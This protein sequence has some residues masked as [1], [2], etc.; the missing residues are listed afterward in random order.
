MKFD[1]IVIGSGLGGLECGAMLS[2]EGFN[3]CVL[4]KHSVIG[5]CLQSFHRRGQILDTGIHYVGSLDEGGILRQYFKY[6]G[7]WDRLKMKRLDENGFDVIYTGGK[8]YKYPMGYSAFKEQ[9]TE[10]FPDSRKE[11]GNYIDKVQE[12][13]RL[14]G[15]EQLKMGKISQGGL[16]F[17]SVSANQTINDLISNFVLRNVL[18]GN[19]SLFAG[20]RSVSTF[21]HHAM[22]HGSNI[23]GAYRFVD[24]SQQLADAL[25]AVIRQNGGQ[26]LSSSEVTKIAVSDGK[27]THVEV[28]NGEEVYF[29]DTFISNL[30]PLTTY[31]L[32]EKN[33][34][35]KKAY[36]TRLSALKNSYGLFTAYL[37]MKPDTFPYFNYNLYLHDIED[38]WYTT[39]Y[40]DD[41]KVRFILM[42]SL[43]GSR[44][45]KYSDVITLLS[46]MYF[47]EVAQW[48]GSVCMKRGEDY[49]M[50]KAQ[51]VAEMIEMTERFSPGLSRNIQST[52]SASP[53]T[54]LDYTGT[55]E[56]SAY[57]LIKDFKNPLLT[58]FPP[59]TKYENL[60]LTGQ[61][62]NVHGAVGVTLTATLTCAE[63][64][65][66]EYLAKKIG[67]L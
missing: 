60:L 14:I 33:K 64:L 29:A 55:P 25:V 39:T 21:Y 51:K 28:N 32:I 54:Y 43:A 4:E 50:F 11:I 35:T 2:K 57:G 45:P 34:L 48:E 58:L 36:I 63:L 3:V 30:H 27:I 12:V 61:N 20:D 8:E 9:M 16:D 67:N 65:G 41:T 53:L 56:G 19:I 62:L 42:S 1:I 18:A 26:V 31:K 38:A 44:N 46:P 52:Y 37:L 15:V 5:G 40:P 49:E 6:F 10:Y 13:N 17:F 59:R 23:E 22:I 47:S 66:E 7:I 24:G